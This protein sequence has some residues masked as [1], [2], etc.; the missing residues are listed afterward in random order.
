MNFLDTQ[1]ENIARLLPK[2]KIALERL[3]IETIE[4]LLYHFPARY[5][6]PASFKRISELQIGEKAR[7]W[8]KVTNLGYEKTWKKKM[9]IAHCTLQDHTGSIELVWFSQPYI[10][11][12]LND[13]A[14]AIFSGKVALRKP[15][16]GGG[17]KP[18]IANPLY[19]LVPQN[20]VPNFSEETR[21]GK[22]I[23]FYPTSAG[24]SSLWIQKTIEK[25][26]GQIPV[27][28]FIPKNIL[29]KYHLPE[30]KTALAA[31]H[32]P[33]I[34]E[35]AEAAKKRF[36][37]EGV[38]LIQL[39]RM[40]ARKEIAAESA[41]TLQN[42]EALRKEF[43]SLLPFSLTSAQEKALND[44]EKD[45]T[46]GTPM[47]RLLEG[48]V[49]SGKTAIAA[50]TSYITA[51]NGLQAAYMAPTEILARQHFEKFR[52]LMAK[53]NITMGLL[54]SSISDKFPSKIDPRGLSAQ[55]GTTHVSKTQLLKWVEDGT[56]DILIGTH[57]LI[58]KHVSFKKLAL[59]MVD[60]QHRFGVLQRAKLKQNTSVPHFLTMSATPI[61]RTLALSVYADLD[62]SLLDE[63]PIGRKKIE[64]QVIPP[65]KRRNAYEF[66][67]SRL[68]LGEQGFIVCPRI[69][70]PDKDKESLDMKSVMA[71]YK[72]LSKEVF[73][74][75]TLGILHG[76]M[77]PKEKEEIMLKMR[78]GETNLLISTSVIEVGVDI[79]NATLMIIEGAERFGLAQLHQ[80]RG[81][82]GR[83]DKQS[84]CFLF[85]ESWHAIVRQRLKAITEAKNGFELAEYDLQ[86][87][88]AG[89]LL[90]KHQSGISDIGMEALK[91][92]KMVEAARTEA[93]AIINSNTIS[94]YPLLQT[95]ITSL[96]HT[97]IH[98]E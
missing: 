23:P 64:T 95:K 50:A 28:E 75:F 19:D 16:R 73:P 33:K 39:S 42:T 86:F 83:S 85:P 68:S 40:Q 55:A 27:P 57:A 8:G 92:L 96:A 14:S 24:V 31:M 54:T 32:A 22:L 65:K 97:A 26:L 46:S 98:F 21:A 94:T 79:P 72:K 71:E 90:G 60:E 30:R 69:S 88:G 41:I 56:I 18:Y 4:D 6:D 70:E 17:N 67:R 10:A 87:R 12:M 82:V 52:E 76:K 43:L 29:K 48:D 89:E 45:I 78:R 13:G 93:R 38:F 47:N 53:K 7:V 80:F 36:A 58:Q 1:I 81:R 11:R 5:E 74:E 20:L 2:Q 84:Y 59:A 63:L 91:N 77:L 3:G 49:G 44:I 37:F 25:I 66:I 51:K 15:A 61:P 9:N 62:V 35:H 34:S